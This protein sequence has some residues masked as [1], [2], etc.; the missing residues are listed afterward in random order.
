MNWTTLYISGRPGFERELQ[1]KLERSDLPIMN[2]AAGLPSGT[3]L[4]WVDEQV[5]LRSVKQALGADL[6]AD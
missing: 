2:G 3:W 6:E 1:S 5:P 4:C